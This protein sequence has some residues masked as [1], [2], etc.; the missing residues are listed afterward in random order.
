MLMQ[1]YYKKNIGQDTDV[2]THLSSPITYLW[3]F[4]WACL[5]GCITAALP[6]LTPLLSICLGVYDKPRPSLRGILNGGCH[7]PVRKDYR[8]LRHPQ[9]D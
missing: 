3:P 6:T 9:G 4:I 5:L 7:C 1:N 2:H 8:F